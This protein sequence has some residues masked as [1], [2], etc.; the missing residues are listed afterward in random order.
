VLSRYI[1]IYH[2]K[3]VTALTT[4]CVKRFDERNVVVPAAPAPAR[5]SP[6]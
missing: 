2:K 1:G 3:K 5:R 6:A 4:F